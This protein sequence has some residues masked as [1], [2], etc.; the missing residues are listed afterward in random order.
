MI[1]SLFQFS[2]Y[3]IGRPSSQPK[4][5]RF[6]SFCDLKRGE[7]R[8][9]I[10][11]ATTLLQRMQSVLECVEQSEILPMSEREVP[12][13]SFPSLLSE[14]GRQALLSA[15][16]RLK[17]VWQKAF[18]CIE[19]QSGLNQAEALRALQEVNQGI[20]ADQG[21]KPLLIRSTLSE[22][23]HPKDMTACHKERCA[24]IQWKKYEPVQAGFSFENRDWKDLE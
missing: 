23:L 8:S 15:N 2:C 9:E 6:V 18:V 16:A 22:N 7:L 14:E 5:V 24:R 17:S 4:Q 1:N 10:Q 19:G 12:G 11:W 21:L 13:V 20:M 3:L